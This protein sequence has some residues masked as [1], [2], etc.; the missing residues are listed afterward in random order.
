[1]DTLVAT[2][3]SVLTAVIIAG[4]ALAVAWI[5]SRTKKLD[6]ESAKQS[7][8]RSDQILDAAISAKAA[9]AVSATEQLT[10]IPNR[11]S[12]LTPEIAREAKDGAIAK[13]LEGL[14][15][16]AVTAGVAKF[17]SEEKLKAV[18][19]TEVEAALLAL[20]STTSSTMTKKVDQ[21]DIDGSVKTTTTVVTSNQETA[22]GGA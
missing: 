6:E 4:G 22:K 1:M 9:T 10:V 3:V 21:A 19:A 13:T 7:K 14:G 17:G 5:N 11:H 2:L 12:K 8:Q 15:P 20:K 18:I 16:E